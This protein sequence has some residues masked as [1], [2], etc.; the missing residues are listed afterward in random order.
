MIEACRRTGWSDLPAIRA[1]ASHRLG[2]DLGLPRA[3]LGEV[4]Q[5][6]VTPIV[7]MVE[8]ELAEIKN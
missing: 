4:S 1:L 6:A 2:I 8:K 3:P 5:A 7:R